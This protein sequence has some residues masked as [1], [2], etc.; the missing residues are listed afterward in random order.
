MGGMGRVTVGSGG[1]RLRMSAWAWDMQEKM[2]YQE[3]E[4]VISNVQ[5]LH[6]RPVM[7]FVD[8][9]SQ[10]QSKIRV[11]KDDMDVDGK[12]PMEMMILGATCGTKLV[13]CA[14]GD[15]AL[16]ALEALA[17]LIDEKFQED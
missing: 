12:S 6:A 5:G 10:Y 8:L 7:R 2:A 1:R 4:V 17:R 16:A 13:L 15:D 3:R 14:D 11:K 9:A